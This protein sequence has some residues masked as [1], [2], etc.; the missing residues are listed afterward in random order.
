MCRYLKCFTN[1]ISQQKRQ[2]FREYHPLSSAAPFQLTN[3]CSYD[4]WNSPRL[5]SFPSIQQGANSPNY[6]NPPATPWQPPPSSSSR[7]IFQPPPIITCCAHALPQHTPLASLD[8]SQL[9]LA[10]ATVVLH[11]QSVCA[12]P[13][14]PPN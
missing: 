1:I 9:V 7:S 12:P 8:S 3:T 6:P 10:A 11:L 4:K 2:N 14:Q 13:Y 5:P